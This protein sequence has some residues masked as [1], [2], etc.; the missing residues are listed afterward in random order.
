M[1]RGCAAAGGDPPGCCERG[2]PVLARLL[3]GG[4][5]PLLVDSPAQAWPEWSCVKGLSEPGKVCDLFW[6]N[7][8]LI[9]F[10][11]PQRPLRS[12]RH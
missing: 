8:E 11:R 6:K 4:G 9:V 5:G 3:P 2:E 1:G 10:P 12:V 7:T